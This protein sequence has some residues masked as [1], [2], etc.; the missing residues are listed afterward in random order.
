MNGLTKLADTAAKVIDGSG[1]GAGVNNT[2]DKKKVKDF[3]N[4]MI[5]TK[6]VDDTYELKLDDIQNLNLEAEFS[7]EVVMKIFSEILASNELDFSNLCPTNLTIDNIN[8]INTATVNLTSTTLTDTTNKIANKIVNNINSIIKTITEH[9]YESTKGD[10]KDLG[11]AVSTFITAG[12]DAASKVIDSGGNA[13]G[14]VIEKAGDAAAKIIEKTG[15]AAAK[16]LA[17]V[18]ISIFGLLG[19]IYVVCKNTSL[20]PLN[21]L[22]FFNM[23]SPSA[24]KIDIP[25]SIGI[26]H[27]FDIKT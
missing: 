23:F 17:I 12:G 4:S 21:L 1:G 10:I 16:L 13:A 2:V 19:L 25:A 14:N 8:Q 3:S 26:S 27:M 22:N 5:D 6:L 24:N 18:L 20:C 9:A 7:P 15:D 11:N